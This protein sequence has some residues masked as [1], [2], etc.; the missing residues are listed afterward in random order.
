MKRV[1][2]LP[3]IKVYKDVA[4]SI[5]LISL[6][7]FLAQYLLSETNLSIKNIQFGMKEIVSLFAI[8]CSIIFVYCAPGATFCSLQTF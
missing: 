2:C 6:H 7:V 5:H 8:I 1:I 4:I 3:T